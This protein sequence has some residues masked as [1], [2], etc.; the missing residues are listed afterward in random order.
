MRTLLQRLHLP[1]AV[2]V[3]P[4]ETAYAI[5]LPRRATRRLYQALA[6][7]L[8]LGGGITYARLFLVQQGPLWTV[9]AGL[10]GAV[11]GFVLVLMPAALLHELR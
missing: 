1:Q 5:Y 7:V 4:D 3:I 9:A 10:V 2:E 11:L 8:G 6:L